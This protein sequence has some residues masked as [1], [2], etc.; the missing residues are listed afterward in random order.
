MV[1]Y[2]RNRKLLQ[3]I[4]SATMGDLNYIIVSHLLIYIHIWSEFPKVRNYILLVI[5]SSIPCA[6]FK[7]NRVSKLQYF[8]LSDCEIPEHL[9][10]GTAW[11]R[12]G[13]RS[14]T[15]EGLPYLSCFVPCSRPCSALTINQVLLFN[16]L[17]QYLGSFCFTLC[18]SIRNLP[19]YL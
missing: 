5:L 13:E 3:K 15:S 1:Y 11:S 14:S 19:S 17:Y 10:T 12:E 8:L 6:L 7:A 16:F 18:D 9:K 2:R 4:F